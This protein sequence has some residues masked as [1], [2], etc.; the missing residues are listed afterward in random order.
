MNT[1][2][3]EKTTVLQ[4][5]LSRVWQAISDA[6]QF[7]AWFGLR[8]EGPFVAGRKLRCT[9]QPTSVDPEI[10]EQQK[11]YEGIAFHIWVREMLPE[12]RFS[13]EWLPIDTEA[14]E[15]QEETAPRTLVTFE[16]AQEKDGV[17][18]RISEA[19]FDQ[20]SP[21]QRA[22]AFMRNDEGWTLQL[23]NIEGYLAPR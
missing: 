10:A 2:R 19:G 22:E 6:S 23:R 7:G 13:F 12:Q 4:A 9:I 5:S 21:E 11:A 15:A 3:I 14:S 18:L 17:R 1:D 20:L 8:A 16:L